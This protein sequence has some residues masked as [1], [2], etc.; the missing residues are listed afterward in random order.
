MDSYRRVAEIASAV[1][2]Q[3]NAS[4]AP[5]VHRP[6]DGRR[7]EDEF[8]RLNNWFRRKPDNGD[9]AADQTAGSVFYWTSMARNLTRYRT[10][11]ALLESIRK[12]T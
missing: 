9:V 8:L 10:G 4:S 2:E 12:A 5:S 6:G 7:I 1:P 11:C 3:G